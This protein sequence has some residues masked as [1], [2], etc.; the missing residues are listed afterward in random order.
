MFLFSSLTL[1]YFL[2]FFNFRLFVDLFG[3]LEGDSAFEA[4]G[5]LS[6]LLPATQGNLTTDD[7]H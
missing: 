4:K 5:W 3:Y 7:I 1:L 2:C 6:A